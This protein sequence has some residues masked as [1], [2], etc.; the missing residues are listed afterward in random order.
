MIDEYVELYRIWIKEVHGAPYNILASPWAFCR[1]PPDI[2]NRIAG[3]LTNI[4]N[5][6]LTRYEYQLIKGDNPYMMRY[7]TYVFK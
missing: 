2:S 7:Y 6:Y 3:I 1:N 4:L 5:R